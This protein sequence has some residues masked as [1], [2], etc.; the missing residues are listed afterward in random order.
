MRLAD[1]VK[2]ALAAWVLR[3][4]ATELASRAGRRQP[5]AQVASGPLPGTMPGPRRTT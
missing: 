5:P 1:L 3:W 2:L 4:L